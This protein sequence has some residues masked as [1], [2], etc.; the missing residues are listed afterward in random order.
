[1][2]ARHFL[3]HFHS[4]RAVDMRVKSCPIDANRRTEIYNMFKAAVYAGS[5]AEL[6]DAESELIE[7]CE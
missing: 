4:F 3:C 7:I 2:N 1:V 6:A 5:L